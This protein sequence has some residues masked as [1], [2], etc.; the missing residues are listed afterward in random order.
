MK[1]RIGWA[2]ALAHALEC[3]GA[4]NIDD[5]AAAIAPGPRQREAIE[6]LAAAA[7]AEVLAGTA[8]LDPEALEHGTVVLVSTA[9]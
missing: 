2:E 1:R 6:A 3:E 9:R 7:K 4:V 5:L 8:R